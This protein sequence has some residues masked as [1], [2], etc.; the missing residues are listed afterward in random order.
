GAPVNRFAQTALALALAL[1]SS[2]AAAL[3]LGQLELKSKLGEPLVA[4]I[5]IISNDPGELERLRARLASPETFARVGL[6]PPQGVVANLQFVSALDARG[7]PVIRVTS[8]EPIQQPLLTFLVEVDWG[9]GRLVR[10]YSALLDTPQTVSA[11]LQ[12]P[13]A[14]PEVAPSHTIVRE[15]PPAPGPLPGAGRARCTHPIGS[16]AKGR[17]RLGQARR[18]EWGAGRPPLRPAGRR[19]RW[20][21]RPLPRSSRPRPARRQWPRPRWPRRWHR[22][23]DRP[24]TARC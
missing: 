11:P 16:C 22:Q 6:Q 17:M 9:Q 13:I 24:A 21:P 7:R 12:P 8:S 10:E 15:S 3:G 1:A 5:Q 19:A 18:S 4:E 14:A 2:S 20:D 23:R